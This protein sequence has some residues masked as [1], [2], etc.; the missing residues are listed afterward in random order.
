MEKIMAI[1]RCLLLSIACAIVLT[2]LAAQAQWVAVARAVSGRIQQMSNK[3][4]N[5]AGYDVATVV[6]LAKADKVYQTALTTMKTNHP[7]ITITSSDAKK[8]EIKFAKGEQVASM[9]ATPL[10]DNMTQLVVA[11][12]LS[13]QADATPMVV[14]GVMKVCKQMNVVCTLSDQ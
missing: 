7:E 11:S 10:G 4:S 1:R 8:R 5:G 2:S 3:S 12:S 13:P 6:L 9:Q 14:E